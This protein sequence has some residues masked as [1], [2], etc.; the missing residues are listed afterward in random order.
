MGACT[1]SALVI[2]PLLTVIRTWTV[3]YW[4][5]TALPVTVRAWARPEPEEE[6]DPEAAPDPDDEPEPDD[7]PPD[8]PDDEDDEDFTLSS[9]DWSD[10]L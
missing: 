6:P 8:A 1:A 10:C 7:E 2:F 3:P 4:V 9:A 5:W